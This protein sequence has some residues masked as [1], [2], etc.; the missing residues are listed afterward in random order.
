[1]TAKKQPERRAD[2]S[3][4]LDKRVPIAIIIALAIQSISFLVGGAVWVTN[5]NA[6]DKAQDEAIATNAEATKA[7]DVKINNSQQAF[8]EVK[9][10]L[11][12]MDERSLA[13][14]DLLKEIRSTQLER[15]AQK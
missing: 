8:Y 13:Q 14:N 6:K 12:R 10:Q 5:S 11:G 2:D 4:H 3:W 9:E 15:K 1:M 7:M